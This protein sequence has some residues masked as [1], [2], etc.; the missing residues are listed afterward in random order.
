[1]ELFAPYKMGEIYQN[2]RGIDLLPMKGLSKALISL[3][4]DDQRFFDIHHSASD[5]YDKLNV[6]EVKLGGASMCT[7]LFNFK[8]WTIEII[9]YIHTIAIINGL[10]FMWFKRKKWL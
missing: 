6:R 4:C 1:M 2:Q 5:T 8:I 3:E 10:I 7:V 9:C